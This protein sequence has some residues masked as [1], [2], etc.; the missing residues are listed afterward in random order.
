[1]PGGGAR[2]DGFHGGGNGVRPMKKVC[3]GPVKG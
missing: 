2:G 3:V 1:M